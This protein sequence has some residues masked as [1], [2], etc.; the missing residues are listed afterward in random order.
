MAC[1]EQLQLYYRL[2]SSG[3]RRCL[4]A[5]RIFINTFVKTSTPA[6]LR[7]LLLLL[8]VV[9]VVVAVA[10]AAAAAVAVE[11]AVEVAVAVAVAVVVVTVSPHICPFRFSEE[12]RSALE[13]C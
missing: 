13:D 11:V 12:K 3:I 4:S 10:A 1:T 6:L 8:V 2:Q 7:L 5:S 9:V